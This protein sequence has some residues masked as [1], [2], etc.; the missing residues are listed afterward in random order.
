MSYHHLTP[1]ERGRIEATVR[2]GYSVSMIADKLGRHKSTV[3]RELRK[4]KGMKY[5]AQTAQ[6]L[7]EINRQAVGRPCKATDE[8][9]QEITK[10][11]HSHWSP[12]QIVGRSLPGILSFKTIYRW[13]Y[14]GI[15]DVPF[16]VLRRKGKSR[17]PQETR[18]K[19]HVGASIRQRPREAEERTVLGHWEGD[20]IV[21]SRG[22]SKGCLATF[23]E[24]KSRLTFAFRMPD[25]SADSMEA[26]IKELI[27]RV[28]EGCV[29]S[30]TTD[31][32][33][34]FAYFKRIEEQTSTKMYFADPYSSWQRGSI[35]NSNGLLREFFPKGT[36]FSKV[37]EEEL[38]RVL[39]SLNHRPRKCL[40]WKTP[41]EVFQHEVLH[42]I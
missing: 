10:R 18:E 27:Q 42:L 28:G 29:Q 20:S 40:G 4:C 32:G 17:K 21:S 39:S 6:H 9:L 34:E 3:S 23:V 13:I 1:F 5:H 16:E 7:Y 38:Q 8:L 12:E 14:R 41:M 36:D 24:R 22:K 26:A 35:E 11:L 25:R 33:K 15:L 31:R 37:S 30:M 2:Q 19:F